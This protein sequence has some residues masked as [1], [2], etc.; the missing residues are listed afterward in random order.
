MMRELE[1][2]DGW[3][4]RRPGVNYCSELMILRDAT[5]VGRRSPVKTN[6]TGGGRGCCGETATMLHG[7]SRSDGRGTSAMN[8][9][10]HSVPRGLK[11][12][13]GHNQDKDPG[14]V[15][16]VGVVGISNAAS[17][18]LRRLLLAKTTLDHA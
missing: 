7:R 11:Q 5:A 12:R 14:S 1:G 17:L 2:G 15:A 4:R 16:L 18:D 9:T 10:I 8:P 13:A 3:R 6:N